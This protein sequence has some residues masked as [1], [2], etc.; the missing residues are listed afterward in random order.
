METDIYQL[1]AQRGEERAYL[2]DNLKRIEISVASIP[3]EAFFE[4]G[5]GP[6]SAQKLTSWRLFGSCISDRGR[7]ATSTE[8]SRAPATSRA[9]CSGPRSMTVPRRRAE[10]GM[11]RRLTRGF[12]IQTAR[13]PTRPWQRTARTSARDTSNRASGRDGRGEAGE[14]GRAPGSSQRLTLLAF[15]ALAA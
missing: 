6:D 10:R 8:R 12:S 14:A 13:A 3:F 7:P 11:R 4:P 5:L 2:I 1:L 9:Q 15:P